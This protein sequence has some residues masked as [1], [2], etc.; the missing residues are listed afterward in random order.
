MNQVE[1]YLFASWKGEEESG[2][3]RVAQKTTF[4][5]F[6]NKFSTSSR[7]L[8]RRVINNKFL[9]SITLR[10]T[11]PFLVCFRSKSDSITKRGLFSLLSFPRFPS[12]FLYTIS[13]SFSLFPSPLK[14]MMTRQEGRGGER[15][16]YPC[17]FPRNSI[18][19]SLHFK[20]LL[21]SDKRSIFPEIHLS[22]NSERF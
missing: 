20:N 8:L 16:L 9:D 22:K 13:S 12:P 14:S 19:L 18:S 5:C 2:R 10:K 11:F 7:R 17:N 1:L 4:L 15:N 6:T 21:F 3:R